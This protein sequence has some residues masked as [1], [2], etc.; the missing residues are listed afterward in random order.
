MEAQQIDDTNGIQDRCR[1]AAPVKLLLIGSKDAFQS[2]VTRRLFRGDRFQ[3]AGSSK[4]LLD[5]LAQIESGA[6]DLVVLSDEFRDGE[7]TLF[8]S[9]AYR[10]GFMGLILRLASLPHMFTGILPTSGMRQSYGGPLAS[11]G[12]LEQTVSYLGLPQL[13]M[14]QW[15]VVARISEGWSNREIA[16]ELNCSEGSVKAIL[17]QI[18]KKCDVRKRTQLVR[19]AI[20]GIPISQQSI[21]AIRVAT[22]AP[23]KLAIEAEAVPTDELA[24]VPAETSPIA[25]GDFVLDVASHR[26]WVRGTEAQLTPLEL[27]LLTFFSRHPKELL[28]HHDLHE[29]AWGKQPVS[30]ESLRVLIRSVRKKIETTTRPRYILTQPYYGYRFMPS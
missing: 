19:F 25:I 20:Q 26:V 11:Y 13:T 23:K 14:K 2:E 7:L 9:D 30:R 28:N 6:I 21:H 4:G 5:G 8:I 16:R 24:T 15:A 17:Q 1:G 10:L 12:K 3:I 29:A 18:F 27:R 22:S